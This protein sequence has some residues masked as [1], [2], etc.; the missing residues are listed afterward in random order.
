MFQIQTS[1]FSRVHKINSTTPASKAASLLVTVD[2]GDMDLVLG[3]AVALPATHIAGEGM[4]LLHVTV[5]TNPRPA[6][7]S[8]I[9]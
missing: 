9:Y 7:Q 5:P 4:A 8:H 6:K 1:V 3:F 2:G